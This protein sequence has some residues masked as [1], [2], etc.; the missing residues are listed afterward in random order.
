MDEQRDGM[1]G[2]GRDNF[3]DDPVVVFIHWLS[4]HNDLISDLVSVAAWIV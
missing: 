1:G 4:N 3:L 2:D